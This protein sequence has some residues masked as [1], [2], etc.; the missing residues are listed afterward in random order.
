[1]SKT[2]KLK[3]P[4]QARGEEVHEL[5]FKRLTMRDLMKM[6]NATGDL[7]KVAKLI[8]CSAQIPASSVADIDAEDIAGISEILGDFFP[9]SLLTGENAQ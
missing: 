5:T 2:Y 7:G 9:N 3:Y 8:E 4:I 6:D 1:M